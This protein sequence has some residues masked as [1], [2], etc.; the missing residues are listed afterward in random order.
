MYLRSLLT[1]RTLLVDRVARNR[2]ANKLAA[3]NTCNH[4]IH[5]V[6]SD[7]RMGQFVLSTFYFTFLFHSLF[8]VE[9]DIDHFVLGGHRE[10]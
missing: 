3:Y 1:E 4:V 10:R 8:K 9:F 7:L 5:L 6:P 2:Y